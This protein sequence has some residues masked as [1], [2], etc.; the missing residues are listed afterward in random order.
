ML[1]IAGSGAVD[2]WEAEA[3]CAA[4]VVGSL[5]ILLPRARETPQGRWFRHQPLLQTISNERPTDC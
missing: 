4:L 3:T 1:V 2:A 5:V